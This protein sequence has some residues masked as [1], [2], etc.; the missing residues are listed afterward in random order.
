MFWL[1][2]GYLAA[3]YGVM[4]LQLAG[5][6]MR[7]AAPLVAWYMASNYGWVHFPRMQFEAAVKVLWDDA[8]G[9]AGWVL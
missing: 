9:G 4:Q 5:A 2:L 7:D 3:L 1:D 6:D 8:V